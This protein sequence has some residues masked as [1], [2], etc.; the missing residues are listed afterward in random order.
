M[1]KLKLKMMERS[2]HLDPRSIVLVSKGSER[3]HLTLL[4]LGRASSHEEI[5]C[6]VTTW[7]TE[8]VSERARS[9]TMEATEKDV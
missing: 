2:D 4:Y 8:F 3:V 1:A 7:N 9:A 5:L 6:L